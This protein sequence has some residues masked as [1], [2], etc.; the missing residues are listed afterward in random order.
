MTADFAGPSLAGLTNASGVEPVVSLSR[1][2]PISVHAYE[3]AG[4]T[5]RWRLMV[6]VPSDGAARTLRAYL[7]HDG[8]ALTETLLCELF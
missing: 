1:G 7:R 2:T 6:D 5:M 8:G 3:V 4:Q